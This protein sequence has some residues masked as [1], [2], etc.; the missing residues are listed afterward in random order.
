MRSTNDASNQRHWEEPGTSFSLERKNRLAHFQSV[1]KGSPAWA[2]SSA[3]PCH[4]G[5]KI[6]PDQLRTAFSSRSAFAE[7]IWS[8]QCV[9]KPWYF[10]LFRKKRPLHLKKERSPAQ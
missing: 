7:Q 6:S 5:G 9:P 4:C 8:T 3:M 2:G 1:S 10:D